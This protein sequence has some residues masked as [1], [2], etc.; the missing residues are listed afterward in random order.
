MDPYIEKITKV[1]FSA[2]HNNDFLA[3]FLKLPYR[4][5]EHNPSRASPYRRMV[6]HGYLIFPSLSFLCHI[7]SYLI[8]D[9]THNYTQLCSYPSLW[10]FYEVLILWIHNFTFYYV[11]FKFLRFDSYTKVKW[12]S[13]SRKGIFLQKNVLFTGLSGSGWVKY[14][15]LKVWSKEILKRENL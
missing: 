4:Y 2:N 5:P 9:R 13:L 15:A 12:E 8:I 1:I 11:S 6:R 10:W 7:R 3:C 14:M